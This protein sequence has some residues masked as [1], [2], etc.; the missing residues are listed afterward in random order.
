MIQAS[1]RAH[2][3]ALAPRTRP[4]STSDADQEYSPGR[5]PDALNRLTASLNRAV[6][7]EGGPCFV[8]PDR[9][10]LPGPAPLSVIVSATDGQS[11][12]QHLIRPD[13]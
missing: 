3:L 5:L 4:P 7:V 2:L 8:F 12:A 9:L 10:T 11:A 6:S 1:P 13:N